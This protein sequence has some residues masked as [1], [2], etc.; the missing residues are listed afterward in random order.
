MS[1]ILIIKLGYRRGLEG[2]VTRDVSLISVLRSTVLLN[3]FKSDDVMWVTTATA[4]PLVAGLPGV[5][6][7]LV[8]DALVSLGLTRE[9]FDLVVNLEPS[10]E[11]CALAESAKADKRFGFAL[12][13]S[14]TEVVALPGA[15]RA[16]A[17]EFSPVARRKETRPY[18]Q[19]L[20]EIIGRDWQGEPYLLGCRPGSREE[21]DVGFN[22]SGGR[23]Y[24]NKTWPL[25]RWGQLGDLLVGKYSVSC[26]QSPH[27]LLEYIDWLNSCRTVVSADTLG[28]YLALA[29]GK[30]AVGLFGPT[31]AA[32]CSTYGRGINL[33][34]P[35]KLNCIPCCDTEGQFEKSCVHAI[36]PEQVAEAIGIL[37]TADV[38]GK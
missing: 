23:T 22:M 32:Q 4:L 29:L 38:I 30:K 25:S 15:E 24:P 20:Y 17:F 2:A 11:F 8:Y 18:Q 14:G 10:W 33:T 27:D 6:R 31:S 21:F 28:L 35:V 7:A 13:A 26:Q 5:S 3:H 34:P 19:L 37:H 36:T 9:S 12:D 16:F 1:R